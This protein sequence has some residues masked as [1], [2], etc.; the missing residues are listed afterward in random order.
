MLCVDEKSQIQALDRTAPILPMLPGVPGARHARLQ[1]LRDQVL[2]AALDLATGKVLGKLHAATARSS[3][4]SSSTR[5]DRVV[6]ADLDVH[7]VL[8]NCATHKTPAIKKWLARAPP[9]RV[10]LHPDRARW[11]NLV[12][13]WFGELTSKLLRRGAHRSVRA[14]NAD[15]RARMKTWN[16]DPRPFVW[17]KTADQ[18]LDSIAR[19]CDRINDSRRSPPCRGDAPTAAH[20]GQRAK[21]G[22]TLT[23]SPVAGADARRD[24][25]QGVAE[26]K[27]GG[28]QGLVGQLAPLRVRS[29][30]SRTRARAR[31]ADAGPTRTRTYGPK[32]A[33]AARCA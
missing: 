6:P 4:C 14:L 32:R 31:R 33:P 16:E 7:I 17:T 2:F 24:M 5:I 23:A 27:V 12:E 28:A 11:L 21:R 9:L 26:V 20:P 10:A 15:I 19:Y 22:A 25:D 29:R 13:R 3:S 8:D 18:I 1:A 30:T